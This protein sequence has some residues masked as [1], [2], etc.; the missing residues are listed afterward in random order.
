MTA[1]QRAIFVGLWG[2]DRGLGKRGSWLGGGNTT[3]SLFFSFLC[4]CFFFSVFF[5]FFFAL[6]TF[7]KKDF[8][9]SECRFPHS[10]PPLGTSFELSVPRETQAP[11]H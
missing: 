4:F 3:F 10:S 6:R 5:F 7:G 2:R 8:G 1:N 11:V 9:F